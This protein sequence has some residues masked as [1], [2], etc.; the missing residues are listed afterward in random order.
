LVPRSLNP[1]RARGRWKIQARGRNTLVFGRTDIDLRAVE[2]IED[3]SQVRT[4]GWILGRLSEWREA[5]MEPLPV[6]RDMIDRLEN[7][8]WNWLTGRH[9]GDLALPR[10]HE[11]LAALNRLRGAQLVPVSDTAG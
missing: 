3:P 1:E 8:D 2:Q 10:P 9:D 4:I 5:S 7:G 6:V 11:V